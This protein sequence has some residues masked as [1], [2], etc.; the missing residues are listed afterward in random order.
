MAI[1]TEICATLKMFLKIDSFDKWKNM[2]TAKEKQN[3]FY[4]HV[5]NIPS[6]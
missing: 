4:I 3:N 6:H 1:M 2:Q 5:P